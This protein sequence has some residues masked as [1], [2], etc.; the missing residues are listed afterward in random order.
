[1]N[2]PVTAA[3][4]RGGRGD[5]DGRRGSGRLLAYVACG[6]LALLLGL[7]AVWVAF[8]EAPDVATQ[9]RRSTVHS[10]QAVT[11]HFEVAKRQG[12]PAACTVMALGMGGEPVG[13]ARVTV[14]AATERTWLSQRVTTSE[15]AASTQILNCHLVNGN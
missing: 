13:R 9:L 4:D 1:M 6:A 14:P 11:V 5:R 8:A 10:E 3:A 12:T 15:R 7:W 2:T